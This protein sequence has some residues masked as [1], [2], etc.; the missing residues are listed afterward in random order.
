MRNSELVEIDIPGCHRG[1]VRP[2]N[3]WRSAIADMTGVAVRY[4][5]ANLPV[6][7][8]STGSHPPPTELPFVV[9]EIQAP[10][11]ALT[12][13]RRLGHWGLVPD[14]PLF[15]LLALTVPGGT[16]RSAFAESMAE[17]LVE[18]RELIWAIDDGRYGI[19]ALGSFTQ[20]MEAGLARIAR[21][22]VDVQVGGCYEPDGW[23]DPMPIEGSAPMRHE[24]A[25]LDVP[26]EGGWVDGT[27]GMPDCF[28]GK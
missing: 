6:S 23:W 24:N 2:F 8:S 20:D 27:L 12:P 1:K 4:A 18:M 25:I 15:V 3:E 14:D 28:V 17:R 22:G 16:I 7:L 11:V 10:L 19:T 5:W 26:E 13:R 9:A 21:E